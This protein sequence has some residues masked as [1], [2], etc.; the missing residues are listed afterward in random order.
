VYKNDTLRKATDYIGS[1]ILE[2]DTLQFI[3]TAEGRVVPKTVDGVDKNEYQYHLK[4]YLGNVRTTFTTKP[5]EEVY[6][7]SF[8]TTSVPEGYFD[9]YEDQHLSSY[10][11]RTGNN[12]SRLSYDDNLLIGLAKS[13]KVYP[14]D[15]VR[16]SVFARVVDSS[17]ED[18]SDLFATLASG[19]SSSFANT[20]LGIE[21]QTT[22]ISDLVYPTSGTGGLLDKDA[23]DATPKL[24]LNL[25]YFDKDMNF[26]AGDFARASTE[27]VTSFEELSL[28]EL[29]PVEG[30]MLIYVSNEEDQKNIAYFD[31]VSIEHNHS[32]VLQAD[33]YYPFG[34]TFNSYQRSYSKANNY[35]YN[36]KELE[37]ETQ[38]YDYGARFYDPALGRFSTSDPMAFK[39]DW[40]SPYNY[41]QNNP[42]L[43]IDP[44]GMLDDYVFDVEGN[45]TGEIR[46]TEDEN[47]RIV[48]QDGNGNETTYSFN[49][50]EK[51]SKTLETLVES[52]GTDAKLVHKK[53]DGDIEGYMESSGVKSMGFLDRVDF[54]LEESP[55]GLMD[56]TYSYLQDEVYE[57]GVD[58]VDIDND[59]SGF[60][61]LDKKAYNTSDAGNFLWGYGAK[62]L[63]F[64]LTTAKA[65]AH[66]HNAFYDPNPGILDADS[67]QRAIEAGPKHQ[68]KK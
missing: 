68:K 39:R 5:K 41:V 12:S 60:F 11:A 29:V 37:E 17:T 16:A 34:L 67:D 25:Q 3:Q 45:F 48:Q 27:A 2:N 21:G 65:G 50:P 62:K 7:T 57:G 22:S 35:K 56:F 23:S 30:Y 53:S 46:E 38:L 32:P 26:I 40:L 14:G 15:T 8:E 24:Y 58:Y 1:L 4:D 64:S 6:T 63:G 9:N 13:I 31:D 61:I 54:I 66:G 42:I 51:D 19:F 18:I 47:H 59:N 52:Y 43:R 36:S 55:R 49:D 44:T 20:T 10:L 28:E 33:D